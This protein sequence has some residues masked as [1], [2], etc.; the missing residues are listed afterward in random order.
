MSQLKGVMRQRRYC[1]DTLRACY[2]H[3]SSGKEYYETIFWS[4]MVMNSGLAI[5]PTRN[6]INNRGATEGSTHFAGSL[7]TM[8]RRLRR[9]FTMRRFEVDFPLRHP[10][11]VIEN[12]EYKER[13][14]RTYGYGHPWIKAGRSVEELLLNLRYGN[15]GIIA[16]AV[17]HRLAKWMGRDSHK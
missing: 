13:T 16:R 14:Y 4:A 3:R 7:A 9:L 5:M 11:Y 15:F 2:D 6:M 17:R 1:A 8:P 10:R 12:V